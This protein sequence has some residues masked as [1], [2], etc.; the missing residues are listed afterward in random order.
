MILEWPCKWDGCDEKLNEVNHNKNRKYCEHHRRMAEKERIRKSNKKYSQKK[1]LDKRRCTV[2]KNKLSGSN[3][4]FCSVKCSR[5]Y[6]D[7]VKR[8]KK[9]RQ[10]IVLHTNKIAEL[11]RKLK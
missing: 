3:S 2:C 9:I 7:E 5:V 1:S 6:F 8:Q 11:V 10:S 4:K